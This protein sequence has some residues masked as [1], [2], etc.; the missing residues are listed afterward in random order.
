MVWPLGV[1]SRVFS[2][3]GADRDAGSRR[4]QGNDLPAPKMAPVVAVADGVVT[5]IHSTP[6]DDCCW[7]LITHNDGWQ[8]LYV[9]LN[10]DTYQTD[11]GLGHGV[12]PGLEVGDAVAAGQVVGWVGDSGNAEE[13]IPHLHFEL[14]DPAGYSVD[15]YASLEAARAA[16][17]L[18]E[19]SGPYLDTKVPSVEFQASWLI[20]KGVFWPCDDRGL[21]FCPTRLAQPEDTL[22]LIFQMTGFNAPAIAATR[23]SIRLQEAI[24]RER[25]ADVLGCE[26][27]EGCVQTGITSGD[28]VRLAHWANLAQRQASIS[29]ELASGEELALADARQAERGLR[30]LGIMAICHESID[31]ERMLIRAEVARLLSWWILGEGADCV[32]SAEPTS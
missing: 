8:S 17:D 9:H 3:F 10:N 7:L 19:A 20:T 11:D 23:R 29:D 18:P 24:P 13:S 12:K 14:R 25:I 28:L 6:P 2:S 21:E 32:Q 4:H 27:T 30:A 22:D 15:P 1:D 16:A 31:T 26:G 5:S